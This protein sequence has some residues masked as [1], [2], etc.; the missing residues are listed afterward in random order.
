MYRSSF[1]QE[2]M[3]LAEAIGKTSEA[4]CFKWLLGRPLGQQ[5]K[6]MDVAGL[7]SMTGI[8]F[9]KQHASP[10]CAQQAGAQF[11]SAR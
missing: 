1:Y 9:A 10:A 7:Q 6:R 11:L 8:S 3:C 2:Q 5:V 4:T